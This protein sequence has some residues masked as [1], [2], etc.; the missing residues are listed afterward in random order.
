MMGAVG[1]VLSCGHQK[2]GKVDDALSHELCLITRVCV[3]VCVC[4][5][6]YV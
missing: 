3:C 2:D 6:V 4:V 1:C 5:R